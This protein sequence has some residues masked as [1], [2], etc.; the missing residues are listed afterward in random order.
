M[1]FCKPPRHSD[2]FTR[3]N[4]PFIQVNME[5]L[6]AIVK[7]RVKDSMK[8]HQRLWSIEDVALKDI[9]TKEI[10]TFN[11]HD[12]VGE[13]IVGE[14]RVNKCIRDPTNNFNIIHNELEMFA[15]RHDKPVLGSKLF[16]LSNKKKKIPMF[17]AG[18]AAEKFVAQGHL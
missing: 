10:L 4:H 7:I 2:F 18:T 14:D 3:T 13:A 9:N 8:Q 15:L 17:C 6:G 1:V 11:F 12:F 5:A 16:V